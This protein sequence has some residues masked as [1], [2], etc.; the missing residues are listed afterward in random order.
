MTMNLKTIKNILFA[1][2]IILPMLAAKAQTY[3]ISGKLYDI[4]NNRPLSFGTVH[5]ADTT[6]G[7]VT[8]EYGEFILKVKS[9]F[10]KIVFSY[11]GY[12]SDTSSFMVSDSS[13]S[14]D[15]FL[16]P[17]EIFTEV[18]EVQGEDPAY[19]IVRNAIRY[20]KQFKAKLNEYEYDAYS[21][22]I[23]RSSYNP[24]NEGGQKKGDYPILGILESETKGYFK[25]P[26]LEKQII[27][28]KRETANISRGFALPVI[29]NFYDEEVDFGEVKIAGPLSDGAFDSYE[30][31]LAGTTAIDST[32]VYRINVI[33]TSSVTP[34]FTGEIYIIDSL[35]ALIKVDLKT[36]GIEII[37]GVE[38]IRF[39]QKFNSYTDR[40]KEM[41]WM[42]A[43]VQIYAEGS[44]AG[45]FSFRGEVF[46]IVSD[47]A[48]NKKAPSGIFDEFIVKVLPDSKKDSAYWKANQPIRNTEEEKR[49]YRNIE[50]STAERTSK[51]RLSPTSLNIGKYFSSNLFD[52]YRFSG[53]TGSELRFNLSYSR[54][55]GK[56]SGNGFIGYG[57]SDK[58]MKYEAGITQRLLKDR[59]LTIGG[60]VF[61]KQFIPFTED[62]WATTLQ[63][64]FSTLFSKKELFSYYYTSGWQINASKTIIPQV[65]LG[66]S[67][68]QEKQF[69]A[70]TSTDFSFFKKDEKYGLNPPADEVFRRTIGTDVTINTNKFRA[71]DWGDGEISRFPITEYPV[72]RAGFEY[73]GKEL[74]SSY[75]G[76][77]YYVQLSGS[78]N[79]NNFLRI[80][81]KLGGIFLN[82]QLQYQNLASFNPA[83]LGT[84]EGLAFNATYYSEFLGS[85]VYYFNF[86]N[87][88][89][90]M[91]IGYIPVLKNFRLIGI[92]N[93][94][95]CDI[96]SIGLKDIGY[97]NFK[98]TDGIYTEAGFGLGRI[99]N[100]FRLNFV[101]RLNNQVENRNF[102]IILTFDNM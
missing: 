31:K 57:F 26:D 63:N 36:N 37:R 77:K 27:K 18:I 61:R 60:S 49:A 81:Y 5:I 45:L 64:T 88:F 55:F 38:D 14:R 91:L 68:N 101:W 1:V 56:T 17:A 94:G 4:K 52:I 29:V 86:E 92:F 90:K 85:S 75:S 69:S 9:G 16:K 7:T 40:K 51:I 84:A 71:I 19:E 89:G 73:T 78:S 50:K 24:F 22:V 46:T 65:R 67:L 43:D 79:L 12:F 32:T 87:D 33:N 97:K 66:L 54:D 23:I 3:T 28:S 48:L 20:K 70:Y 21:K 96:S 62:N 95:R 25:K 74:G 11:I 93:A 44:F 80:R 82:G 13:I 102:N 10:Y 72:L 76:R 99:L 58:K 8:D 53:I 100:I 2:F 39:V 15:I 83:N 6:Y 42:P 30:Y 98:Q 47:Y 34:Q 35:Y 59:S 41:F